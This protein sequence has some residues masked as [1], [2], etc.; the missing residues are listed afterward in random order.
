VTLDERLTRA[1]HHVADTV[2][3]PEVD[4]AA[5]RSTS[6]ANQRRRVTVAAVAAVAVAVLT[7]G[8]AA[9]GLSQGHRAQEPVHQPSHDGWSP[10]RIRAE[11]VPAHLP[12]FRDGASI[13]G[14][15]A[16]VY[17][18]ASSCAFLDSEA[19]RRWALE[20]T[21][22]DQS[23][24][25][26][27]R[28]IPW[29]QD[30]DDDS[31]LVQDGTDQAVRFR[32]LQA[33]G[34][35]VQLRIGS[36]PVPAVPGPGVMLIDALYVY[37]RGMVGSDDGARPYLVDARAGTIRPLDVPEQVKWWGPNVDEF[38]WGGNGCRV[39]WQQSD[40][41]FDHHDAGCPGNPHRFGDWNTNP[42]SE[43]D[44]G[45][46][47]WLEPG[48]MAIVKWRAR[49]PSV[50]IASLDRG[51]TWKRIEIDDGVNPLPDALRQ[52]G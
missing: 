18:V 27:V 46:A 4:L 48:R 10:E 34:T 15:D 8:L 25:F 17:C 2:T 11:G 26:D 1:V 21:Q 3:V 6:R 39:Y 23:S 52:L 45:F 35:A 5:V 20:V 19:N 14:L 41:T 30:F 44:E 43:G 50:M 33:D 16:H 31:I 49:G 51:S 7:V 28:G 22:G 36:D 40:G 38:L 47:E 13:S 12:E 32:L 24:L 37:R 9:A 42:A 29:G